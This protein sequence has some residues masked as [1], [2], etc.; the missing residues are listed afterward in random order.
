[1]H[2][3]MS[4]ASA[5]LIT[6]I[7]S[8][9]ASVREYHMLHQQNDK[10]RNAIRFINIFVIHVHAVHAMCA[11]STLSDKQIKCLCSCDS[12]AEKKNQKTFCQHDVLFVWK[13]TYIKKGVPQ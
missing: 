11:T 13:V 7:L 3:V 10:N 12:Y 4:G 6:F 5:S 8:T 1:M 2:M 9:K